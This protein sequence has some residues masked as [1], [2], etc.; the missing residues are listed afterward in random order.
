MVILASRSRARGPHRPTHR[1]RR[2]HVAH[3]HAH[4]PRAG[5]SASRR[6]HADRNLLRSP[7]GSGRPAGGSRS[8][9]RRCHRRG[10]ARSCRRSDPPAG[11]SPMHTPGSASRPIPAPS[12]STLVNGVRSNTP[13]PARVAACS[14]PM[15]GDQCR[16]A[17]AERV[18]SDSGAG[19]AGV[20]LE[21]LRPLPAGAFDQ[22]GAGLL[23]TLVVGRG[24]QPSAD[25][26]SA[27]A[28]G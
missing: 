25:A 15:M 26:A 20:R 21:P 1:H 8:G 27:A 6:H 14:R 4:R 11:R 19:N 28:G 12:T 16:A 18:W 3:A 17:Q 9:R 24:A 5:G 22:L 23:E 10:R 2:G 13:T 7:P